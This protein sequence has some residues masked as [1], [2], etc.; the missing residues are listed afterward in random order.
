MS[1]PPPQVRR[2]IST[3]RKLGFA[4]FVGVGFFLSLELSTRLLW[5]PSPLQGRDVGTRKFITWLSNLSLQ[6]S[7][8]SELYQPHPKRGW[9]LT[10]GTYHGFNYHFATGRERQ[11]IKISINSAGYRGHQADTT[12]P[13]TRRILCLGDSNLFG[14]PLDDQFTFPAALER[15]LNRESAQMWITINGGVP[16]YTSHQG[17]KWYADTFAEIPH[18]YLILS[19]LNNDAWQQPYADEVACEIPVVNSWATLLAS[20]LRCVQFVQSKF[21]VP[22]KVARVPLSEFRANYEY[23]LTE[24][25]RKKSRVLIL[26]FCMYENYQPYSA[27]LEELA[28]SDVLYFH[29]AKHAVA[30]IERGEHRSAPQELQTAVIRRWGRSILDGHPILWMYAE[31]NPEH[32]NEIG[33]R[34]LASEVR[35]LM[36]N[37]Q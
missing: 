2:G 25:R 8:K 19:Y 17:R 29:V 31:F 20:N 13:K 35:Q 11:P 16:G 23:F 27:A 32:L 4:T 9:A 18:D 3:R 22:A 12:D 28:Q 36:T 37:D 14:Y 30:A 24:A 5:S 34:W 7:E 26:D 21:P 33:T 1:A 10:P 6:E 15:E